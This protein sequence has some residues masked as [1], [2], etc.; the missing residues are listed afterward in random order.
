MGKEGRNGNAAT[1]RVHYLEDSAC[2]L[3]TAHGVCLLLCATQLQGLFG[4]SHLFG[5]IQTGYQMDPE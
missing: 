4:V 3:V 1:M 2:L 5:V